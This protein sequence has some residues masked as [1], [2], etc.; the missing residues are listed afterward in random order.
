MELTV[1]VTNVSTGETAVATLQDLPDDYI[2]K[3]P[4]DTA[5][6][7]V[8]VQRAQTFGRMLRAMQ[9]PGKQR[10]EAM[11]CFVNRGINAFDTF[12]ADDC[13]FLRLEGLLAASLFPAVNGVAS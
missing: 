13:R 9:L 7:L 11:R 5:D 12:G 6:L 3:S 4:A 2:E 10:D 1:E 8:A